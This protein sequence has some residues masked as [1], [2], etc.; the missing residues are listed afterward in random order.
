[1]SG[2]KNK[3]KI[4]K[5]M[6]ASHSILSPQFI[7]NENNKH[8]M[9]ELSSPLFFINREISWIEFNKK[10]L[11][12]AMNSAN[13]PLEQLK[14]L[15]IFYNNLD[16][17]F[18]VRVANLYKQYISGAYSFPADR[19]TPA[20]TLTAIRRR[21]VPMLSAAQSF[22]SKNLKPLLFNC[23]IRIVQY[24]ALQ[25]KHKKF[26]QEYYN[27]EIYPILTPQ[28]IDPGRPF[29]SIS[30]ESLNFLVEL[31]SP[32]GETR[33]ARLKIPKNLGRF[34]FIPRNKEAKTSVNLG[35]STNINDNDILFL[36][37]VIYRNLSTLFP[38]FHV[39]AAAT[40]RLTRNTDLDIETDEAAD[41]LEA[42]RDLVGQRRFGEVVR[43]EISHGASK[44]LL[45]FLVKKLELLPFQIYKIKGPLAAAELMELYK[46]ERPDL[47]DR[48]HVPHVPPP[49]GKEKLDTYTLLR[50]NDLLLYH[51][52]D[53]FM[54]VVD[55]I[56][57]AAEDP[58]VIAIKQTLYRVGNESPIVDALIDAKRNGKQVTA[59]VEL[60]A[61]FDEERNI[62]WADTFE[63]EGIHVVYGL[64]GMKI[65]AKLC[66]VVR[67]EEEGIRR[68]AHIG[69]GNYNPAT[70]KVYSDLG[71]F[72]SRE[73][74][75]SDVTDLFNY[76]TGY[77]CKEAYKQLL[78][79]P[80]SIRKGIISR[81]ERETRL[82]QEH[83]NGK[84]YFKFNH[85]VDPACIQALFRA[86]Q[87]GVDVRLQ[88]RGICCLRP[89]IPGVSDN[90]E[91]TSLVGR[92]LEHTRIYYFGCGGAGELFIGS[93]DLMPRNLDRRV[94]VLCPI[95]DP[96]L[97]QT[98]VEDILLVHMNDNAKV[99]ILKN[100]GSYE[101]R[102]RSDNE[103]LIDSQQ[104][105]RNRTTGWNPVLQL[106][107]ADEPVV[108]KKKSRG[109]K[110]NKKPPSLAKK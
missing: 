110:N 72:T 105:M 82:H 23:G 26:L 54:P 4:S 14:F 104:I 79:A 69:T 58:K 76:M 61:R 16:E 63:E 5:E 71:F 109:H 10:V 106:H 39:V 36:E 68:Y 80:L 98:I 50:Q 77:T 66:L 46:V 31:L 20:K 53:S 47:K 90:I 96:V 13:P 101:Q 65:H 78:V 28:A 92:F 38:G 74:I 12:E 21:I 73:D 55:F 6:P 37:E 91:V 86:S 60:K 9:E 25:E 62:K 52:Y 42:I 107:T 56:R 30:S 102:V 93:A 24:E 57:R 85:L 7:Q 29:P 15:S 103:P 87:A 84:I 33:F 1:M 35:F 34:L 18:M 75:C 95:V 8:K 44:S 45:H 19:M 22:W 43:L 67:R 49:F 2:L 100:D 40:F 59:V 81:I 89:G 11:D 94:E 70:A 3:K 51:P 41:L 48:P 108:T 88:V 83:G 27:N 32:Y 99:R 97:R 64:V 17:F